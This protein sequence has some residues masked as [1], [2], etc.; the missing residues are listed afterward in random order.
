DQHSEVVKRWIN[1]LVIGQGFCPWAAPAK[2]AGSIRIASSQEATEEGVLGDLL[3][4]ARELQSSQLEGA[5]EVLLCTHKYVTS[6]MCCW[7]VLGLSGCPCA[8]WVFCLVKRLQKKTPRN[9]TLFNIFQLHAVDADVF[10]ELEHARTGTPSHD[11]STVSMC[12]NS[13]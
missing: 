4:E 13:M 11:C 12:N 2:S 7:A 10:W 3:S 5:L 1:E 6:V 9:D 8:V